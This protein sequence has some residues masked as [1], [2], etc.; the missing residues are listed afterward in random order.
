MYM[1][2]SRFMWR[3][4]VSVNTVMFGG[5][6]GPT[7]VNPMLANEVAARLRMRVRAADGSQFTVG[8]WLCR[9]ASYVGRAFGVWVHSDGRM[10]SVILLD[11]SPASLADCT[12]QGWG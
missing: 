10:P 11:A 7:W 8:E 6:Y 12:R 4:G 9:M 5:E 2:G 1:L 3:G